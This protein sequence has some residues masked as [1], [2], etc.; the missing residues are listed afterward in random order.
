[1]SGPAA[2]GPP[3]PSA[4]DYRRAVEETLALFE[5]L[6]SVEVDRDNVWQLQI[7]HGWATQA[8][9]F[10]RCIL[11]LSDGGFAHEARVIVR[12]LLEYAITLH[13]LVQVGDDAVSAVMAEH[14]R[15][16]RVAAD[17]A[18]FDL[19]FPTEAI[20]EVLDVEVPKVDEQDTLRHFIEICK[21]LGVDRDLYIVYRV[22]C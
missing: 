9:R 4:D 2:P 8:N 6:P 16:I 7:A 3:E 12:S 10:A 20:R 22:E 17:Q 13:W 1:M 5:A 21:N 15:A 11:V 19:P 18:A 14:Q